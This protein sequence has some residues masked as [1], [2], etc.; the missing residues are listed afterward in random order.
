M[1]SRQPF[2]PIDFYVWWRACWIFL[3][4]RP[5]VTENINPPISARDQK[6]DYDST[7]QPERGTL[8][9]TML[10]RPTT[11]QPHLATQDEHVLSEQSEAERQQSAVSSTQ[12]ECNNNQRDKLAELRNLQMRRKSS[13]ISFGDLPEGRRRSSVGPAMAQLHRR[14]SNVAAIQR[15][16]KN[17]SAL[18]NAK[19][20][21]MKR[22]SGNL[23]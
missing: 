21:K 3:A 14:Q 22:K 23:N 6:N 9:R 13:A 11:A 1:L 17:K 18:L 5:N 7:R 12:E 2:P 19:S 10:R 15:S 20:N 4:P 8:L 16:I